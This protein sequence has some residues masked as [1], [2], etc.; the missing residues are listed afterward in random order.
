MRRPG[1]WPAVAGLGVALALGVA[2]LG[3]VDA[4]SGPSQLDCSGS[5]DAPTVCR[6]GGE[7]VD[8][9]A[10]DWAVAAP[11]FGVAL[12]VLAATLVSW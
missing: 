1:S 12:L 2:W 9:D 4:T 7:V 8:P 5:S 6:S 3:W 11:W 10:V